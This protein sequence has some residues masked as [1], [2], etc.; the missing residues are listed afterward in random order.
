M[1]NLNRINNLNRNSL[2]VIVGGFGGVK[3]NGYT[4][5]NIAEHPIRSIKKVLH[6]NSFST[7]MD[8]LMYSFIRRFKNTTWNTTLVTILRQSHWGSNYQTDIRLKAK[9]KN[10]RLWTHRFWVLTFSGGGDD[11]DHGGGDDYLQQTLRCLQ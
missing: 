4:F 2:S 3:V 5:D 6:I 10:R 8:Y 9:E 1:L 11:D 7:R